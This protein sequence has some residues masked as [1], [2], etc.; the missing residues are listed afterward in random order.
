MTIFT[1]LFL[2]LDT[3]SGGDAIAISDGST[4]FSDVEQLT[5]T[6]A[7]LTQDGVT[8]TVSIAASGGGGAIAISDGINTYNDIEQITFNGATISQQGAIVSVQQDIPRNL[9]GAIVLGALTI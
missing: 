3:S 2:S 4:V 1:D 8:V 9:V 6:G 5:F 7:T